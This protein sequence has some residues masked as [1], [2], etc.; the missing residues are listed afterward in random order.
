MSMVSTRA[1]VANSIPTTANLLLLWPLISYIIIVTTDNFLL[2]L[3]GGAQ[4]EIDLSPLVDVKKE[5][6]AH[7]TCQIV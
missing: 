6:P 1:I 3:S 7:P 2:L 5:S 4:L